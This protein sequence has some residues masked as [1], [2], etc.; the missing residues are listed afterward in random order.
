MVTLLLLQLLTRL[1]SGYI[2][3]QTVTLSSVQAQ[4]TLRLPY[5]L[6][7]DPG[8]NR[9]HFAAPC[10]LCKMVAKGGSAPTQSY[11]VLFSLRLS[12]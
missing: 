4:D 1:Q 6:D 11:T 10:I 7:V 9:P 3:L 12:I 2:W 8:L 5:S